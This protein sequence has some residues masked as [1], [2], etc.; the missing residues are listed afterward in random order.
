MCLLQTLSDVGPELEATQCIRVPPV[1]DQ[2]GT[3]TATTGGA[4]GQP[5]GGDAGEGRAAEVLRYFT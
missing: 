5:M 3:L 2:I 1:P 4:G